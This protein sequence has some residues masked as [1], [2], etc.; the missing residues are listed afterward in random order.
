MI[1]RQTSFIASQIA[2]CERLVASGG[3][4]PIRFAKPR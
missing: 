3:A 4:C 1:P 2:S